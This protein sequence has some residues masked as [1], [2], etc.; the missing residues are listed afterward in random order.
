MPMIK[1]AVVILNYN[2]KS[3]LSKFLPGVIQHSKPFGEVIVADNASTDG[4]VDMLQTDFP[5][6]RVIKN[7]SNGGFTTGYNLALKQIEAEYFV[8]LNS[9]IEVSNRWLEPVIQL[10]DNDHNIAACQPKILSLVQPSHFEYAGAGG[11]FIDRFGYPFCRGRIFNHLE[12]DMGQYND[13]REVFWASGACMFVRAELYQSHGGLDDS[14]FAHM[15]EID[16]CWRLKNLGY[17]IMYCGESTVFHIGGGTLPKISARKT[18]YNFRNNLSLLVKNL[19]A[20]KVISII[21]IR[22]FLDGAASLK[23]LMQ[24]GISHFLAVFRAHLHFYRKLPYLMKS[25]K[26]LRQQQ[27][28]G[29]YNQNIAVEYFLKG[30]K[31]FTDLND[32][33]FSK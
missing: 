14:F 5:D 28:S 12:E 1:V 16:Y 9:D 21:I 4:S 32:K 11:G 2:G 23:F 27:V 22:L 17:K 7:P 6:I 8:L 24:G 31:S 30:K 15:E 29:I 13:S 3:Y 10:M 33:A 26:Q 25:R 19:P 20:D 18:Y